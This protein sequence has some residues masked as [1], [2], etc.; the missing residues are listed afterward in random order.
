MARDYHFLFTVLGRYPARVEGNLSNVTVNV[1]AGR[2]DHFVHCGTLTMNEEEWEAFIR[3]LRTSLG[4][5]VE[6]REGE[7]LPRIVA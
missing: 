2:G 3:A 5:D 1:A 7:G 4:D 6:V